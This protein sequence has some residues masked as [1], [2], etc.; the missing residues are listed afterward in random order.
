MHPVVV[1]VVTA[2]VVVVVVEVVAVV[3]RAEGSFPSMTASTIITT[4]SPFYSP[5]VAKQE[6]RSGTREKGALMN[7]RICDA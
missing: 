1:V 6:A 4:I 7:G 5:P 3:L 2:V